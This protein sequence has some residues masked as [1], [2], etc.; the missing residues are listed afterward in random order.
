MNS[1][2]N[3]FQ[4]QKKVI[5]DNR[6]IR[7]DVHWKEIKRTYWLSYQYIQIVQFNQISFFL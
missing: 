3:H 6:Y 2:K 4:I 7:C 1:D 5:N